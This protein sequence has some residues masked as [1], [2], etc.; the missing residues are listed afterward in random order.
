VP[1]VATQ[2]TFLATGACRELALEA[3]ATGTALLDITQPFRPFGAEPLEG[4]TLYLASGEAF[5]QRRAR[6]RIFVELATPGGPLPLPP[7]LLNADREPAPVRFAWEYHRADGWVTLGTSTLLYTVKSFPANDLPALGHALLWPG[8][9]ASTLSDI[10]LEEVRHGSV[11]DGTEGFRMDGDVAFTVPDDA[12]ETEVAGVRSHWVRVRIDTGSYGTPPVFDP[13]PPA[14]PKN[15]TT[16]ALR[17]GTGRVEPPVI[18]R[19]TVAYDYTAAVA[20]AVVMRNGFRAVERSGTPATATPLITPVEDLEPAFYAGFDRRSENDAVSLWSSVPPRELLDPLTTTSAPAGG[21]T[22]ARLQWE[23]FGGAGWRPLA[24]ADGT[25]RLTETGPLQF[26]APADLAESTEFDALPRHWIRVRRLSGGPEYDPVLDG[27]FLNTVPAVQSATVSRAVAGSGTGAPAQ[28]IQL[29][30]VPVLHGQRLLVREADLPP[31]PEIAAI[32][33][34]EGPGA[35]PGEAGPDGVWIRWHEVPTLARSGPRDRHYTVE[36][37]AGLLAFGD[38]VHALALPAGVDNVAIEHH[39]TTD[40]AAGNQPP[41]ALAQLQSSIPFVESVQNP[42]AADGGSDA[43]PLPLA[44]VRGPQRLRNRGRAVAAED[45]EWAAKEAR[46]TRV[47]RAHA[48]PNR[49]P[50]QRFHPGWVTL[51]VIPH[52]TERRLAPSEEL[53]RDVEDVVEAR[54][55][56]VVAATSPAHLA[57]TGPGYVPVELA[58]EVVPVALTAAQ[59]VRARVHARL[60]GF[61][62][63][64]TGGP[65][66]GG[67]PLGRDV[68]LSELY[69][70]LEDLAVVDHVHSLRLRPNLAML[71][72]V[73]GQPLTPGAGVPAGAPLVQGAVKAVP[74]ARLA[75]GEAVSGLPAAV[76][77]EGEPIRVGDVEVGVRTVSGATLQVDPFR[78]RSAYAPG[79]VV[80]SRITAARS[81]L[82]AP[83]AEGALVRELAV[84]GLSPGAAT[85]AGSAVELAADG[86]LL[87]LG[88]R[89]RVPAASL[90]YSGAHLVE[91]TDA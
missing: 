6:A 31:A 83:L 75:A 76:F 54:A 37:I 34:D 51:I 2:P 50:Q 9:T 66:G 73:L 71:P 28:T 53:V 59:S 90:P 41:G 81:V 26:L 85:L 52:G 84:Q 27:L 38:N 79:T 10:V 40:G 49:D 55:A 65:D 72:L 20:T 12:T 57:V 56:A 7:A 36:R 89:V 60:D 58:V 24:V 15:P 1:A 46:G 8:K 70:A 19:V 86:G 21:S 87:R 16:F 77:R 39:A 78:A 44:L 88:E 14:D 43:E 64:L 29:A 74:L 80:G 68:H 5:G 30:R 69:A 3:A 25:S 82:T 91:I 45:Y 32:E 11:A 18:A 62:H 47:A 22:D 42:L 35:V 4:D 13:V 63:A 33:A 48:L 17:L 67:W 23:Y 61:L